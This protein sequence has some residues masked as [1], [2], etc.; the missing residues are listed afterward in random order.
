MAILTPI[1]LDEA[2]FIGR[3]FGKEVTSVTGLLAGSVNSNFELGLASGE[4]LFLRIYEEQTVATASREALLLAHLAASGVPTPRP[5]AREDG[6]FIV[7]LHE[8]PAALFPF[9]EGASLCQKLLTP[10]T[11]REL[12][13]ALAHVHRAGAALAP[14]ELARLV[15]PSRFD[16]AAL[17][18]RIA[19]LPAELPDEV[20]TARDRVSSFLAEPAAPPISVGLIHGDLFRDNVLWSNDQ[21]SAVLDFESASHGSLAFDLMVTI[22]AWC[23]GD[24][25]DAELARALVAG[26][27]SVAAIGPA[28]AAEL[29]REGV[30][31]CARFT[32]TRITDF[33]LR[34]RGTGVYK[35][36]R[37]FLRRWDALERI[38]PAHLSSFLHVPGFADRP[39]GD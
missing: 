13:R 1:D 5:L 23:F 32:T 26:Y 22:L 17:A 8:K 33:E 27:A 21:I 37:R 34:P 25:L 10:R 7:T 3:A 4:R 12:G 19:G 20:K 38:G 11:T 36:Y 15:G 35:D 18:Q 31:A 24:E 29:Y 39:S 16:R 2:R 30:F 6:S 14:A 28:F 9:E